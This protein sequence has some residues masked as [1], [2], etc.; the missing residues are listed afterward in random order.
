MYK[1]AV[2]IVGTTWPTN[3]VVRLSAPMIGKEPPKSFGD[4]PTSTV[5]ANMGMPCEAYKR[6]N[7]CGPCRACWQVDVKNIDYHVQ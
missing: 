2:E 6:D 3:L 1:K 7:K 5:Q 4:L